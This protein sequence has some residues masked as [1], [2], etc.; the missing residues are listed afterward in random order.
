[1]LFY[2][3]WNIPGPSHLLKPD[4]I[5]RI[6]YEPPIP[7]D[8]IGDERDRAEQNPRENVLDESPRPEA[9]LDRDGLRLIAFLEDLKTLWDA[10]AAWDGDRHGR[11]TTHIP[12]FHIG[13]IRNAC[14]CD[15]LIDVSHRGASGEKGPNCRQN[16]ACL[17][18]TT[19][20]PHGL[21]L[22]RW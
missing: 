22:V 4:V 3:V 10:I 5:R 8:G 2:F 20:T 21:S 18:Q 9:A 12:N 6:A 17:C 19:E 7:G 1:M 13:P 15:L 16:E 11:G 14:D